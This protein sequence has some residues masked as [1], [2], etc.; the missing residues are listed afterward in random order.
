MKAGEPL[1]KTIILPISTFVDAQEAG[2]TSC[3]RPAST[4]EAQSSD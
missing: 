2:G 1:G 3:L 4:T